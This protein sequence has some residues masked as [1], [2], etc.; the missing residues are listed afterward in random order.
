MHL[1]AKRALITG[2]GSGIGRAL[3]LEGGA[4]GLS[5]LL[6]GRR[7]SA[8]QDT[9]QQLGEGVEVQLLAADVS[10]AEDRARIK[11]ALERLGGLDILVNNAGQVN[12]GPLNREDPEGLDRMLAVNLAAPIHLSRELLPMIAAGKGAILNVGSM[13]GDIAFPYFASY[14]A[15]KF[16]LRGFSDALRRETKG[17][18]VTVTYAAPRATRTPAAE[19]FGQLVGPMK[20]RLDEPEAVAR[21]LWDAVERQAA[22]AY[23]GFG[24]RCAVLAQ[25]L[26]P[27]AV[28]RALGRMAEDPKVKAAL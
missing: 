26:L 5:L 16:G 6:T 11:A 19:S 17:S 24:E 27:G 20:M 23:P 22:N 10:R 1:E 8:L 25:R 21:Q 13:F 2:A 9:A 4:R 18:G 7:L 15:S 28:D 12:V 3:A 14:S